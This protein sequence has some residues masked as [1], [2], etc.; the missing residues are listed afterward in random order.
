LLAAKLRDETAAD[1]TRDEGLV[2]QIL[3][4]LRKVSQI[5]LAQRDAPI[6]LLLERARFD[7]LNL[8]NFD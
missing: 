7:S 6:R 5:R 8:N 1:S 3:E 4:T 2:N